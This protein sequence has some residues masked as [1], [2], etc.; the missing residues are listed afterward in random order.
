MLPSLRREGGKGQRD[1]GRGRGREREGRGRER[2]TVHVK[3]AM[4]ATNQQLPA[5]LH[6]SSM[7]LSDR[8]RY[9]RTDRVL[10]FKAF[11]RRD[12]FSLEEEKRYHC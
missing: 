11:E 8:S 2:C 12:K 5:I 4:S 9:V 10:C 7:T 3:V 1:E 6:L